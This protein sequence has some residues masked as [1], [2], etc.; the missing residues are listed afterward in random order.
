MWTYT[1]IPTF[2]RKILPLSHNARWTSAKGRRKA[3]PW[4]TGIYLQVHEKLQSR[5]PTSTNL[6]Q[7]NF[8]QAVLFFNFVS[9]L[10]TKCVCHIQVTHKISHVTLIPITMSDCLTIPLLFLWSFLNA[11]VILDQTKEWLWIMNWKGCGRKWPMST[12]N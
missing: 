11:Y 3:L 12:A 4:N 10:H 8:F 1:S 7:F 5:T 9:T 2:W 6:I